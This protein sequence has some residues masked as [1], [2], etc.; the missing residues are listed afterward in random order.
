MIY[1]VHDMT[2]DDTRSAQH[3]RARMELLCLVKVTRA[4]LVQGTTS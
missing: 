1:T 3:C 4:P 2:K